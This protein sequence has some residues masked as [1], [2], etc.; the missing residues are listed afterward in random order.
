[1]GRLQVKGVCE[2]QGRLYY[3]RKIAGK[4]MYIR[5]PNVDDPAFAEEYAQAA[6]PDKD[7]AKAA[8]G[9]IAA[10]VARFR[11]EPEHRNVPSKITLANRTRYLALIEAEH[12][13]RSVKGV[14][15]AHVW[16]MRSDLAEKP[17]K[18][19]NYLSVFRLLMSYATRLDW[20]ADN[21]AAK[22]PALPLG[23]HEPWPA[24]IIAKA[25][26]NATP[27]TR[28][29]IVTGLC[30]G[31]RIGDVIRMQHGWHDGAII[32]LKQSKTAKHVAVPMHPLWIEE[33]GKV[34]RKAMTL[35]YDRV[36]RPFQTTG[37]LQSR[38]RKLMA[39]IGAEGFTFHGLR[40][41]ACCYLLELGLGDNEVG[42][43]LGMSPDMVRH[44]GKRAR[45]LMIARGAADRIKRGDVL[46]LKRGTP[47]NHAK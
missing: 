7:R 18:A 11:A 16:K 42:A 47:L 45:V 30:S 26:D 43:L 41:N 44:Y 46:Q 3:R 8:P 17:G 12:G 23:E 2:K 35:L 1:M 28:L 29:A 4:D 20:R 5:L 21:P 40:K 27:M 10:L 32:Q 14:R 38:L 39:D 33:L 13:H 37:A 31:Q 19:N 24:E 36:G 6:A 9:S 34:E 15:P 25:L 22:I